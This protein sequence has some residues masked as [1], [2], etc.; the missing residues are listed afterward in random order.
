MPVTGILGSIERLQFKD[1]TTASYTLTIDDPKVFT[2]PWAQEF[3]MKLHPEWDATGLLESFI[4]EGVIVV[5]GERSERA[6][7]WRLHGSREQHGYRSRLDEVP[8]LQI[9]LRAT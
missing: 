8:S 6:E 4:E 3:E 5:R 7:T 2:A 9:V 1:K